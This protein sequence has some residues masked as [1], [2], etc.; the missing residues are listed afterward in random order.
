MAYNIW[1]TTTGGQFH[2]EAGAAWEVIEAGFE[3]RAGALARCRRLIGPSHWEP[4]IY[5]VRDQDGATVSRRYTNR[6]ELLRSGR[7]AEGSR[8]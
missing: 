7:T 3:T 8:D 4:R 5:E 1:A 2:N 6:P